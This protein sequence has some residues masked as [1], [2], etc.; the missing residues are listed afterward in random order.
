LYVGGLIVGEYIRA[1]L[2]LLF[3]TSLLLAAAALTISRIRSVAI[4]PLVFL[5][6]WTNFA[7]R[8]SVLSPHDLRL[9]LKK[10][11]EEIV[12]LGRLNATPDQRI[13]IHN[14]TERARTLAQLAVSAIELGTRLQPAS[15]TILITTPGALPREFFAGQEVRV[16]GVIAPPRRPLA[17][18]LFDYQAYLRRQEIYFQLDTTSAADWQVRSTNRAPPLSDRFLRWA[19][20][21]MARGLPEEDQPLRLLWAMTL[22][23]KDVLPTEAY[24]PFVESGTMHI[25][26]ISGLHIALIAG[27]LVSLLRVL[28]VSR[29]WCG[30]AVVPVI[31]FYTAATGWQPSAVRSTVMMTVIIAGWSLKRPSDLLNSLAGAA[32]IILIWDPQQLFQA[33]FQLSFFVVLSIALLLPPL[34]DVRDR[35]LQPD[36]FLPA[37]LV[38]RWRRWLTGPIRTVSTCLITSLAAW[39]GSWPLTAFYFH[40]FSPITLLAN[41]LIVPLSSLALASNLGSLLCGA[42][43]PWAT[44]LFNFSAWWWMWWMVEISQWLIRFPGA[45]ISVTSPAPLDFVIY[46]SALVGGLSGFAFSRSHRRWTLAWIACVACIYPWRWHIARQTTCL[47]ILPLNGGSAIYCDAPGTK[48]D[49]LVDCGNSNAVQFITQPFLRANGVNGLSQ[50]VLTHGDL[51]HVGGAELLLNRIPARKTVTS[52]ARFRSSVYREIIAALDRKPGRSN[53]VTR[54]DVVGRFRVLHPASSDHF[55][56]ADDS[57]LVLKG[58]IAGVRILLLSDLGRPGQNALLGNCSDLRADIV[59]A[60]LPERGEP[61]CDALLDEIQPSFVIIADSELPATKRAGAAL[62]ERLDRRQIPV[63][64]TRSSGAIK[65]TLKSNHWTAQSLTGLNV[66]SESTKACAQAV[67]TQTQEPVEDRMY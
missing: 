58:D 35:L 3:T 50:L 26:A 19:K 24:E 60:C 61:L 11:A 2:P 14:D 43:F 4:W 23:S 22:G 5:T 1:P 55:P 20:N 29:A 46:Y 45:S 21:T 47:T 25:F 63:A 32:L 64:F 17:E 6:G 12:V 28:Q 44:E 39:L 52:T 56:Q 15:G 27:I 37:D 62:H 40:L 38:P 10:P 30:V 9:L 48:D 59:V 7:Y 33:S 53:T 31:W 8:T 16:T 18:G 34:Q 41:L 65:I 13:Y 42:W 49:V 51:R 54:G 36:P 67:V 66:S 57:S